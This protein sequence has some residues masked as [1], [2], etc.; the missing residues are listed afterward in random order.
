MALLMVGPMAV[1]MMAMMSN[2][3]SNKR[4]NQLII[5]IG[6]VVFT[7]ALIGLRTQRPINDVQYMRAMIPHHSSA[8]MTSK[9]ADIRDPEVKQLSEQIIK[10]QQI[11]I[12]QMEKMLERMQEQ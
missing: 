2:M 6:V 3:Y 1:I 12:G 4:A 11:E 9:H 7:G 10:S 5:I 8:I